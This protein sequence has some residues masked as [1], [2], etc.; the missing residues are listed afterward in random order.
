MQLVNLIERRGESREES[1]GWPGE[2]GQ[3]AGRAGFHLPAPW[4]TRLRTR[5]R[6]LYLRQAQT[7]CLRG[8]LSGGGRLQPWLPLLARWSPLLRLHMKK[9]AIKKKMVT[10]TIQNAAYT[11]QILVMGATLLVQRH[12][13]LRTGN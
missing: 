2:T 9:R 5:P 6:S 3:Q 13:L 10:I 12:L 1:D 11:L 7:G 8:Q 4:R